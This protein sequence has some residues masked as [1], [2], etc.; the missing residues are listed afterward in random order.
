MAAV[1]VLKDFTADRCLNDIQQ[2]MLNI[3]DNY[4]KT[5]MWK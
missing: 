4:Y 2:S 3:E 5:L 1:S